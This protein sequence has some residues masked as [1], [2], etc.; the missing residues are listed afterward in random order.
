ARGEVG[1][2]D[3]VLPE[4]L[5]DVE[6]F[7]LVPGGGGRGGRQLPRVLVGHDADRH[8]QDDHP[9]EQGLALRRPVVEEGRLVFTLE[10]R[11]ETPLRS[12][13]AASKS[14]TISRPTALSSLVCS[15][16]RKPCARS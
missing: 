12:S 3:D 7:L 14:P 5:R 16:L 8:A 1:G 2:P 11:H 15:S 6:G 9:G 10:R 4:E 13:Q